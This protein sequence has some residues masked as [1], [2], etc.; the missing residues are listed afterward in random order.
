MSKSKILNKHE[1]NLLFQKMQFCQHLKQLRNAQKVIQ[2]ERPMSLL[3]P[4]DL[5]KR[6]MLN[7]KFR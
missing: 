2:N 5:K 1:I 3:K 7:G 6:E 4:F